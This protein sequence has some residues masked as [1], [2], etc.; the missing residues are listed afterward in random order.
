MCARDRTILH[1]WKL[2]EPAFNFDQRS[3]TFSSEDEVVAYDVGSLRQNF[4]PIE[5]SRPT[6]ASAAPQLRRDRALLCGVGINCSEIST[7]AFPEV[8]WHRGRQWGQFHIESRV[9]LFHRNLV[10]AI[11]KSQDC[12]AT[13]TGNFDRSESYKIRIQLLRQC[14]RDA[15]GTDSA[16]IGKR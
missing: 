16:G 1:M 12:R 2:A 10:F 8:I 9:F 7:D 14:I 4:S 11:A 3:A 13:L 15:S 5:S 6:A